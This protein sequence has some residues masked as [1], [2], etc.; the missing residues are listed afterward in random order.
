M[1]FKEKLLEE[2]ES[3]QELLSDMDPYKDTVKRMNVII[4]C[5]ANVL[6]I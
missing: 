4:R 5:T 1:S 2:W 3:T 6:Y